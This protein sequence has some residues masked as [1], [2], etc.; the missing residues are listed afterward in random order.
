MLLII[1]ACPAGCGPGYSLQSFYYYK[2]DFRFYPSHG[3]K[4]TIKNYLLV[5]NFPNSFICSITIIYNDSSTSFHTLY[6]VMR[7]SVLSR[8]SA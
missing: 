6:P 7:V 5:L 8:T 2:K 3:R 4:I 1:W